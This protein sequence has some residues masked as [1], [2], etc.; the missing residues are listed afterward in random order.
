M[1]TDTENTFQIGFRSPGLCDL[2]PEQKMQLA[3]DLDIKYIEPQ[4]APHEIA[5]VQHA[6]EMGEAAE[7][8]NVSINSC[9][10][11]LQLTDLDESYKERVQFAIDACKAMNC[12]YVFTTVFNPNEE[13]AQQTTWERIIP[14]TREAVKQMSEHGIRLAIEPDKGNFIDAAERLEKLLDAVDDDRLLVNFDACNLFLSGSD[15]IRALKIFKDRIHSGHIKDGW[16]YGRK[17]VD[18]AVGEGEVP[19]TELIRSMDELGLHCPMHVEHCNSAESVTNAVK[20][21]RSVKESLTQIA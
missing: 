15:P 11:V 20:H 12:S 1:S 21:I 17:A 16:Y 5:S 18:T 2:S 9:G 10:C 19:W 14:R 8:H 3:N 7:K 13:E 4:C 6:K